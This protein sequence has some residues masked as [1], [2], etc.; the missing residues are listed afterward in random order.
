MS[1]INDLLR[2]LD[3]SNPALAKDLRREVEA[4]TDRRAF[5]LN[6]ERHQPEAVELPGRK[7]RR[8]DKVHV[9]PERGRN[10]TK[11]NERLWRVVGID[12]SGDAPV[13]TLEPLNTSEAVS[14]QAPTVPI[15]DLVVVSEFRDP[16]YPG[17]V[18]TGKVE[19]GGDKPFHTVINAENYHA[20]QTLLFTHRGQV[21]C[22]YID[23]PYNTGNEG[24][25]YN[26]QYVAGDDL[27]KHSKWLAFMERRLILAKELLKPTGVIV[28]AIGDD[29]HHRLRMLMD[30][31][32]EAQNYL[33]TVGW[34]G[35]RK[36]DSRYV[37]NGTDYM[38]I[39]AA[40]EPELAL[41]ETRWREIKPGISDAIAAAEHAWK[42]HAPDCE[43]ATK[44]YRAWWRKLA[45]DHP[46]R[47]SAHYDRVDGEEGRPGVPYFAGDM[48]SPN[49]RPNL[50][51]PILHPVTQRPV[52]MHPNG[53]AYSR[54]RMNT[55]LAAGRVRF[56]PDE[57]TRPTYKRYLDEN[58]TQVPLDAFYA[59][60]RTASKHLLT[61]LGDKRFPNPKDHEVLSRWLAT[62]VP[63][64]GVVLD[65][66]GGSGST[67]ETVMR[68][69]GQDG[70]TRRCIL[71]T[72]NEAAAADA[73]KLRKA[74]HRP[75]D[76]EWEAK[77]V[78]EYVAKPRIQTVAS[79]IRLDGSKYSDGLDQ[80]VEFFTL[81][82]EAP[83]LV[84]T[85][86][87]FAK[88]APLLWMRAGSLGRRIDSID[89]GW[90]VS[91]TYGV[92]ADLDQSEAF[93]KAV[94][95]AGETLRMV[96][97]VTDEDRLFTTLCRELPDH[98]EPVRLYE[99]Y[100]R[101]FEIESGRASL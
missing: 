83:L 82:Y 5:G 16:I 72:N 84:S 93:L 6:F 33:S 74:D 27:Y 66:F 18:S 23:P 19:R 35:G 22:I 96:F 10:P 55:L 21:D 95:E 77:G 42:E 7:V 49:P 40:S 37:S 98:V 68:L 99:A 94:A 86:R 12:R 44:A 14:D 28:V 73:K 51:Y 100:L 101:N 46:A 43:S 88:V 70:G 1:R 31:I 24:W 63:A 8:G 20:L 56:G 61:I 4:L 17:L 50:C 36:N 47:S 13:A 41:R 64:D 11:E 71:V 91:D 89:A 38:L 80:N 76:P 59:D 90:D 67:A 62:I 53:W 58:N 26:D 45:S 54:D 92:V 65:F 57:K 69:N 39:Y 75:G 87:E 34:Q 52:N 15:A 97:I 32:F 85:N 29:E 60:R 30:Q 25:I 48:R 9:L 3:A 79:G 2:Q 78:Y 81:T